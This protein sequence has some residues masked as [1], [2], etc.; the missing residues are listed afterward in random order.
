MVLDHAT[1]FSA[2]CEVLP[3]QT[4]EPNGP[5]TAAGLKI[6]KFAFSVRIDVKPNLF[7]I[8]HHSL[9][10]LMGIFP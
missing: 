8:G 10:Q 1:D 9:R 2:I 5:L 7:T 3:D 6:K 4:G